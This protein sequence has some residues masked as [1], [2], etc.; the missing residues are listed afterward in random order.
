[1]TL[2]ASTPM[3]GALVHSHVKPKNV[4][5]PIVKGSVLIE[6]N[7]SSTI[8]QWEDKIGVVYTFQWVISDDLNGLNEHLIEGAI[9]ST[10]ITKEEDLNKYIRCIVT[11]GNNGGYDKRSVYTNYSSVIKYPDIQY[12]TIKYNENEWFIQN[13][14]SIWNLP[15]KNNSWR[16]V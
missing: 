5:L 9:S 7:I 3:E 1:M 4:V 13:E 16:I 15:E 8:G 10:Y 12:W 2:F 14:D 11:A 6:D